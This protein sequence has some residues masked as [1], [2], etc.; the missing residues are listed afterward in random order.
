MR[1]FEL[2]CGVMM[3]TVKSDCS[4]LF[5]SLYGVEPQSNPVSILHF[6]FD[7]LHAFHFLFPFF[8]VCIATTKT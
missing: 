4:T 6:C 8:F 5:V 2:V 7:A 1:C 3:E